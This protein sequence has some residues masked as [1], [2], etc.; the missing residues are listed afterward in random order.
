MDR[1]SR[2]KLFPPSKISSYALNIQKGEE[3]E[4]VDKIIDILHR[5]T[6]PFIHKKTLRIILLVPFVVFFR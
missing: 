6:F 5:M 4:R 2:A 3:I 1:E